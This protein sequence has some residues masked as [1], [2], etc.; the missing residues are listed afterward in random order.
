MFQSGT[1]ISTSGDSAIVRFKRTSACGKCHACFTL[2]PDEADI[3]VRNT[4]GVK[5]GDMVEIKMH[6]SN[7]VKASLIMYGLP[8]CGLVLGVCLGALVNEYLALGLGAALALATFGVIRLLEPRFRKNDG[9][10]PVMT[11][12]LTNDK[13]TLEEDKQNE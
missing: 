5:P 4:L 7:I 9:F 2:S 13:T 8:L 1:V 3:E 11:S 6:A 12:I 10:S